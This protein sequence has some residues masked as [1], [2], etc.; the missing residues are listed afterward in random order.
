[1][2]SYLILEWNEKGGSAYTL[3]VF[4]GRPM[5]NHVIRHSKGLGESL[6]LMGPNMVSHGKK[7]QNSQF[8]SFMFT[9]EQVIIVFTVST[10]DLFRP[11]D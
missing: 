9:P 8:F 2:S 10:F 1:V 3:V 4:Q 7:N 5:F 6:P 11:I